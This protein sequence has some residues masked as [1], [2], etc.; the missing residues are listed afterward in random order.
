[1]GW[2]VEN[3]TYD[4]FVWELFHPRAS[5]GEN[6]RLQDGCT[7]SVGI[8]LGGFDVREVEDSIARIEENSE[9]DPYTK[10][11]EIEGHKASWVETK[12]YDEEKYRHRERYIMTEILFNDSFAGVILQFMPNHEQECKQAFN[13][14]IEDLRIL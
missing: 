4:A 11:I 3:A 12:P 8:G 7:M 14:F 10:V 5:L 2:T 1:D 6:N 13:T 9:D